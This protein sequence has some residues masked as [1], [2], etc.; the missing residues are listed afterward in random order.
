MNPNRVESG[1]IFQTAFIFFI[2]FPSVI[3]LI[4]E[5]N[6]GLNIDCNIGFYIWFNIVLDTGFNIGVQ[7]WAQ[8]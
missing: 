8:Y 2:L 3:G 6:I 5:F 1:E 4:L 7:Y